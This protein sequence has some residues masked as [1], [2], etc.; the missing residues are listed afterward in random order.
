[1]VF[2]KL[3]GLT[4]RFLS[5]AQALAAMS[6]HLRLAELG[7]TGDAA[8]RVQLD[9]VLDEL[10]VRKELDELDAGE[11]SVLLSFARSYLSQ[12]VDLI[13]DPARASGW[14][15]SDAV[16][17]QAQGSASAVVATLISEAGLG[18]PGARV[19]D[20]GTGVAGLATAFCKVFP[21]ATVVG[22]DPWAPSLAIAR[23]NVASAGLDSRVTLVDTTIEDFEDADG[24]DLVWLPSFFIPESVL[25]GAVTRVFELVQAGG[26]VVVGVRFTD[27]TDPVMAAADDLF[28]VRSG[29]SVLDPAQ[30]ILRLERAGFADVHEVP[31]TWNPPLR[32]IVGRRA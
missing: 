3:M 24:F 28:T 29:G 10:G 31:R 16:L 13:E 25:D 4:N 23:L 19:L 20:V 12:A 9:R 14:S 21:D 7:V 17:L 18:S 26:T 8:V 27:E 6:A 5:S 1:M 2:D 11:R 30:A 22:I 32:F 15:H